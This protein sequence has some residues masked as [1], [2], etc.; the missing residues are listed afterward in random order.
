MPR[1]LKAVTGDPTSLV[2]LTFYEP[3]ELDRCTLMI[4]AMSQRAS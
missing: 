2:S 1:T 3:H 4:H